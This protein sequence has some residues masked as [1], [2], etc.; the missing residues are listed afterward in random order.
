M[1][2]PRNPSAFAFKLNTLE[3]RLRRC[4]NIRCCL[5]LASKHIVGKRVTRLLK[6]L[7]GLQWR[8]VVFL[9]GIFVVLVLCMCLF[10]SGGSGSTDPLIGFVKGL[11][12]SLQLTG[13]SPRPRQRSVLL[14]T[15]DVD[16][17]NLNGGIGTA[18]TNM[19]RLLA[20]EHKV[21]VL[22]AA[23]E[24]VST[25]SRL[26]WQ[27]WQ[28]YFRTEY[29]INLTALSL[30]RSHDYQG[31]SWEAE[32]SAEVMLW[33]IRYGHE[34]DV[35]HFHDWRGLGYFTLLRAQQGHPAL[36]HLTFVTICHSTTVW[37]TLGDGKVPNSLVELEIDFMERQSIRYSQFVISPSH[38]M[39][40]WMT[41]HKFVF[42]GPLTINGRKTSGNLV[43]VPNPLLT[44]S[45]NNLMQ[46]SSRLLHAVKELVF[47]GRLE[48]RKGF[49]IFVDA[50][51]T[52]QRT[53]SPA[54]PMPQITLMGK[55]PGTLTANE[56]KR[57]AAVTQRLGWRIHLNFSA[58]DAL[59]YL[60]QTGAGRVAV[61]PSRSDN[62]PY[63]VQETL[64]NA[65]PL[66]ASNV[67][68]MPELIAPK[69]RLR[70]TFHPR[71]QP[72]AHKMADILSN[73]LY[74]ADLAF[75]C[76]ANSR[77]WLDWHAQV[78]VPQRASATSVSAPLV[79][80]IMA[81]YNRT[82]YVL[83]AVASLQVQTHRNLEVLVVDDGTD[84]QPSVEYLKQVRAF[85]NSQ[86]GWRFITLEH[87]SVG[88]VRNWAVQQARGDL[89]MFM[90]DDNWAKPEEV[91]TFVQVMQ[92]TGAD[93]LTCWAL[94]FESGVPGPTNSGSLWMF[95]GPSDS[96]SIYRNLIG[97]SNFF[98]QK[99][100]FQQ[101][102]GFSTATIEDWEFL[103]RAVLAGIHIQLIPEVWWYKRDTYLSV[104]HRK[105][106]TAETV[107][108]NELL[109]SHLPHGVSLALLMGRQAFT[110][111]W[112][113]PSAL[114]IASS[115]VDFGVKQ[116]WKNWYYHWRSL[117][118]VGVV[119]HRE[120]HEYILNNR[121]Q[122]EWVTPALGDHCFVRAR[123][124]HPCYS[125]QEAISLIRSWRSNVDAVV[126]VSGKAW[127]KWECGDGVVL[128]VE[129]SN[130]GRV[131]S[132]VLL[133]GDEMDLPDV[134]V[135]VSVDE[136]VH[137]GVEP[138]ADPWCDETLV[139]VTLMVKHT[140]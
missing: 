86:P 118:S 37:A 52:L 90:D 79:T 98:I 48:H 44:H 112:E 92:F 6:T 71:A 45:R 113:A 85:V 114:P 83:E 62:S 36:Q 39:F 13:V 7:D 94:S 70:V 110:K 1:M 31:G 96:L 53:A 122:Q 23:G 46:S 91:A 42:P 64:L 121:S 40:K 128:F 103:T 34:F 3:T 8:R 22:H 33:L 49:D 80:V 47:F 60:S 51:D 117:S 19:G 135:T 30:D 133:P 93:L 89:I 24:F 12:W 75:D 129:A 16:G 32:R 43:V 55:V 4:W 107:L 58:A 109:S 10:A 140:S 130:S 104:A 9:A 119:L 20:R 67:G 38:Y 14:V 11:C 15:Y 56:R 27:G 138:R 29:G 21:T 97:D 72:L 120:S 88:Q 116:G 57:L 81:T 26:S 78:P 77:D 84:Y 115:F 139:E 74:P 66:I 61:I 136:L 54:F 101:L 28:L 68:G 2:R 69:D 102:G 132:S 131:F 25:G 134:E 100:V 59:G 87:S 99:S 17:P 73:G 108:V 126:I 18:N 50:V 82:D 95:L 124:Q 41:E 106:A 125:S 5:F 63:T 123:T 111:Q 105:L 35:V 76:E 137:I 65:I 127:R